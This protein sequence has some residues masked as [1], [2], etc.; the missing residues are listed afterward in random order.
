VLLEI[1]KHVSSKWIF[2]GFGTFTILIA[3]MLIWGIKDIVRVKNE[4]EGDALL[5]SAISTGNTP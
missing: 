1:S 3:V 2:E 4:Q 5:R